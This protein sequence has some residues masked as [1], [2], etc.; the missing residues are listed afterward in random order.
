MPLRFGVH[1]TRM[2]GW[3]EARRESKVTG[4]KEEGPYKLTK[5]RNSHCGAVETH[6]TSIHEVVG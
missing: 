6:L 3:E 1:G 4:A 2:Q 5:S